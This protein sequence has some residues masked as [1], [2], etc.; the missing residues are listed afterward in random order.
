MRVIAQIG[1]YPSGG[2]PCG[3]ADHDS[4]QEF[5]AVKEYPGDSIVLVAAEHVGGNEFQLVHLGIESR[6]TWALGDMDRDGKAD[7]VARS[8]LDLLVYEARDSLGY[9]AAL[10]W[11]DTVDHAFSKNVVIADLDRDSASEMVGVLEASPYDVWVYENRGADEYELVC[12]VPDSEVPGPGNNVA[13][14]HDMDRDGLPELLLA[15]DYG[16]VAFYEAVGDDTV[17]LKEAVEPAAWV[18]ANVAA[19]HDMDGDGRPEAV[20]V[21]VDLDDMAT[22]AICESPC[23]DSFAVVWLARYVGHYFGSIRIAAGDVDGDGVEEIAVADGLRL[24]LLRCTGPDEYGQFWEMDGA[25][26]ILALHD[27]NSD[28]RAELMYKAGQETVI[29]EYT[30]VGVAERELR[31]LE[32]VRVVP[33]VVRAGVAVRMEGLESRVSVQVLDA[34][35]RVVAEPEDGVWRTDGVSPGVYFFRFG[36][37]AAG[38]QPSAVSAR[39]VLVVE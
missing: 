17:E 9:P 4:R 8:G 23:G 31:Q 15:T 27:I 35:G 30:E 29:R 28:G 22:L 20:V 6:A 14:S 26:E 1:V 3:D 13:E 34:A 11:M 12:E 5:Y 36:P 25:P 32:G 37:S 18:R 21:G 7:L 16:N 33:S 24:R 19:T 38:C 10:V 39:K 2:L